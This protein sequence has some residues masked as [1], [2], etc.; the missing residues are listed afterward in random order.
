MSVC[1]LGY[2]FSPNVSNVLLAN[3]VK[4]GAFPLVVACLD[5]ELEALGL[6]DSLQADVLCRL[7]PGGSWRGS[8]FD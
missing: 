4:D 3:P 8:H 5:L 1:R 2:K 7:S 6:E